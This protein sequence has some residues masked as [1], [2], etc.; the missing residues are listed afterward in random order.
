MIDVA[1]L[2][3][4]PGWLARRHYGCARRAAYQGKQ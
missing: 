1:D 4:F 3:W 2:D